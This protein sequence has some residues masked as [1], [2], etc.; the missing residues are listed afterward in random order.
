M[1]LVV[2]ALVAAVPL[3]ACS[4]AGDGDAAPAAPSPLTIDGTAPRPTT[5]AAVT[6]ATPSPSGPGSP[7][8]EGDVD[9]ADPAAVATAFGDDFL[10]MLSEPA[11]PSLRTSSWASIAGVAF[12]TARAEQAAADGITATGEWSLRATSVSEADGIAV[13]DGCI[14][15]TGVTGLRDGVPEPWPGDEIAFTATLEQ[16]GT[17]WL[18]SNFDISGEVCTG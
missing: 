3:A 13:V 16:A 18:A 11:D 7:S 9:A 2:S 6:E 14:D 15:V 17:D 10:A 4:G 1:A 5:T 12:M 8:G